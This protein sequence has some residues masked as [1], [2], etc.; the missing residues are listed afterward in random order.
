MT[1]PV[2][3]YHCG[4]LKAKSFVS[5]LDPEVTQFVCFVFHI[6]VVFGLELLRIQAPN[7]VY[8]KQTLLLF[9]DLK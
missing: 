7:N 6:K 2:V 4:L 8:V 1:C 9:H 3:A 5:I